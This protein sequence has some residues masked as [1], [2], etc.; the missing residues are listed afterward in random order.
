MYLWSI[1]SIYKA[2]GGEYA[3]TSEKEV[4]PDSI[5]LGANKYEI[6]I[7]KCLNCNT[8]FHDFFYGFICCRKR[9]YRE[10][11]SA[12]KLV[13]GDM[14]RQLDLLDFLRRFRMHGLALTALFEKPLRKMAAL[15]TEKKCIDTVKLFNKEASYCDPW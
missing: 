5:G 2:K 11:D 4:G 9:W 12:L 8:L 13:S 6:P 10:Y 7:P 3:S 1:P 14:D 15:R